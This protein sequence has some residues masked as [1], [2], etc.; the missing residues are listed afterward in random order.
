MGD[1]QDDDSPFFTALLWVLN[2]IFKEHLCNSFLFTNGGNDC[3]QFIY[4]IFSLSIAG[5]QL[6]IL[7]HAT[8]VTMTTLIIKFFWNLSLPISS[9]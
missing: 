9:N 7:S 5:T 1:A 6:H 8:G 4:F 2:E 3:D